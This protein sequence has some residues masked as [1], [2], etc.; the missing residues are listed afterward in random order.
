MEEYLPIVIADSERDSRDLIMPHQSEAVKAMTSY[1]GLGRDRKN[2]AGLVVMPTGSGKTYTAVTW[3][4]KEGVARGYRIVWLV[5]RQE[6]VQQTFNEFRKQAPL[7]KGTQVKTL[8]ILPVSGM[9]LPMSAARRADVYVCSIASA[10]NKDGFRSIPGM[11]GVKGRSKVIVV[12]D[13]AHHAVSASYQK[14]LDRIRKLNPNM[15]LLGLT[16]T[17]YRMNPADQ[18]YLQMMFNVNDNIRRHKGKNG[19]VYAVTLKELLVSGFLANPVYEKVRTQLIGEIEYECSPEDEAY[20]NKY[21]ELSEKLKL[22]IGASPARNRIIIQQYL[23]NRERYGKTIIFAVNQMGARL[24]CEAMKDAG[25]SCDYAVSGRAD[26][27]DVINKF[28]NN[29]FD[30]LINVQMLTEGSDIPDTQTVFLTRETNSDSMLMQMIG[31]GL[32]GVEAGGTEKAYIVAFH[33]TWNTFAH[34]LDPGTLDVFGEEPEREFEEEE[35]SRPEIAPAGDTGEASTS[36]E[37]RPDEDGIGSSSPEEGIYAS[38]EEMYIKLYNSVRASLSSGSELPVIPAGWYS[39]VT[40]DGEDEKVLVYKEQL[41]CFDEMKRNSA[42]IRN[43][44]QAETLL[45]LYFSEVKIKPDT[46]DLAL[47]L[48]YLNETGA[49]PPYFSF[50]IRDTLDPVKIAAE[51]ASQF[52]K[53]EDQEAWLYSLFNR[54]AMLRSI[55]QYFFAFKKTVFDALKDTKAPALTT[56]DDRKEYHVIPDHYNLNDLLAEVLGMYPKLSIENLLSIGWS[57]NVVRNWFGLCTSYPDGKYQI[58]INRVL[59]SP[60]VDPEVIK[61]LIFHELLH[62]NGYWKHDEEFRLRE[63]QYP[64]STELD[65]FLDSLDL[66]YNLDIQWKGSKATE[67]PLREDYKEEESKEGLVQDGDTAPSFNENAKG[68]MKGFKYCRNCGNRLPAESKFCD[69]CGSRVDY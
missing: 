13:E 51:M 62:Q 38:E 58:T 25:I 32:R 20:F 42:L 67:V 60:D 29:E 64:N 27:Q 40:D 1:F 55:Y 2:R 22:K 59:S 57:R 54:E 16:A 43:K 18:N 12:V 46:Q 36:Q 33:D 53:E 44:V 24:L 65:S 47:I 69:K 39:V 56:E 23:K 68:V 7:L 6:L 26:S 3:L 66:Q 4:L 63:W 11:L 31:R 34:W 49:M 10:A 30:V 48:D 28:K 19:F 9:H 52:K 5:H 41:P 45:R 8:R 50:E 35:L 37:N 61:Y 14:V 15:V 17:P 21:H